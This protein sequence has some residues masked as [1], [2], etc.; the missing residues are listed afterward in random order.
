MERV[1]GVWV[2]GIQFQQLGAGGSTGENTIGTSILY[3]QAEL[4]GK[5]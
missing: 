1:R 4:R 3:W 5:K 2:G